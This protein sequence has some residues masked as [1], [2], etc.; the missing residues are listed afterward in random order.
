MEELVATFRAAGHIPTQTFSDADEAITA[1]SRELTDVRFNRVD[2]PH[3]FG[4]R[5]GGAHLDK[6]RITFNT[7]SRDTDVDVDTLEDK[8]FFI[9]SP[10]TSS[11]SLANQKPINLYKSGLIADPSKTVTHYRKA[12]GSVYVLQAQIDE[13]DRQFRRITG[14]QSGSALNF[15][16]CADLRSGAGLHARH[17]VESLSALIGQDPD[18]LNNPLIRRNYDEALLNA[19]LALPGTHTQ[20]VTGDADQSLAPA[21]VKLAEAYME[22][23]ISEPISVSDLLT[24]CDCS[25]SALHESFRKFRNYTPMEFLARL[26]LEM[27]Y[28]KLNNADKGTSVQSIAY[29]CG[30]SHLG[31]FSAVYRK[32]FGELPRETLRRSHKAR[33]S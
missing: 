18:I 20:F 30:F 26:R 32:H 6:T 14:F 31:R 1:L 2:S 12:G 22:A 21:T 4:L 33:H 25:R 11:I 24:I 10:T 5:M 13:L 19:L 9:F 29:A 15:N 27:I 16:Q 17:L 23:N 7:F 28:S 3:K 8:V